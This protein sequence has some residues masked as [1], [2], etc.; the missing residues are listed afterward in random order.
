LEFVACCDVYLPRARRF[1][2]YFKGAAKVFQDYREL[3]AMPGVDAVVIATPDH[4]HSPQT[5]AA[6]KAGKHVYVEKPICHWRQIEPLQKMHAVVSG[7]AECA[8]QCGMQ[9]L[10]CSAWDQAAQL[11]REGRI[12]KPVHAECGY[13]R[14]G[15][16]GERGMSIDDPKCQ[17]G[18]DMDWK[19]FLGDAPRRPYS[20]DRHFRWR[21]FLDY[22]GG[23]VT[24]LYPHSFSPLVNAMGLG[25]P[26]A[27][28]ALGGQ[29]RYTEPPRE[30]PDTYDIL[31]RYPEGFNVLVKG[32]Q[33]NQ[34]P[35]FN[36]YTSGVQTCDTIIRGTEGTLM[37]PNNEVQFV[38]N[39]RKG[40]TPETW[41]V[42]RRQDETVYLKNWLDAARSGDL[43][44][45]MG[46][47][48]TGYR[49]HL[50]LLM[51]VKAFQ[52]RRFVAYDAARGR[53]R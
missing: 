20:V 9:G 43:K 8:V 34:V 44:S 46:S 33:T 2:E 11:I 1:N 18:P 25:L 24:D 47:V 21:L 50:P 22:A 41:K 4:H 29:Y 14:A 38:P 37:F 28:V 23:P 17:E 5:I 26:D 32:T 16:W 15:D 53:V 3:L 49:T 19:G 48:E 12:G 31:L 39:D 10:S 27:A 40:A 7:Q 30:V 36:G 42:E 51:G 6:V 13:F 45:L 35:G 52:E